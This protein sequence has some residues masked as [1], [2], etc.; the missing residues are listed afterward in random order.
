MDEDIEANPDTLIDSESLT[1][2]PIKQKAI[3]A[4]DGK[5]IIL[6]L[7]QDDMTSSLFD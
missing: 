4:K 3:L 6:K 2:R 7:Q 1:P 5:R